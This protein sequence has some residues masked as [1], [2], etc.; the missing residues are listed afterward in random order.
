[1][2]ASGIVGYGNGYSSSSTSVKISKCMSRVTKNSSVGAGTKGRCFA[3][4]YSGCYTTAAA[5]I[6]FGTKIVGYSW[7]WTC[8]NNYYMPGASYTSGNK[9]NGDVEGDVTGYNEDYNRKLPTSK[10]FD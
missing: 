3:I 4:M 8:Y 5:V 2:V 7:Y 9:A 1:M 6:I 10:S